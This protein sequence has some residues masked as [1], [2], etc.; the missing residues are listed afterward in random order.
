M[1]IP[2]LFETIQGF[3]TLQTFY[4]YGSSYNNYAY[5]FGFKD[6]SKS[7]LTILSVKAALKTSQL[8][9]E[10]LIK[11]DDFPDDVFDG[12]VQGKMYGN[13]FTTPILI[14]ACVVGFF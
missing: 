10:E 6:L 8:L 4:T 9:L 1:C 2:Y 5:D 12:F 11:W 7:E 14:I 3:I 13:Y